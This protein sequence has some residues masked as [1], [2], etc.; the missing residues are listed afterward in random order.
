MKFKR[1]IVHFL[2]IIVISQF[3]GSLYASDLVGKTSGE[4]KVTNGTANYNIPIVVPP[5]IAEMQPKLSINYNSNSGNGILGTGFNLSGLSAISRCGQTYAQDGN[6]TGVYYT[7]KDRFMLGGSRLIAVE[8]TYGADGTIYKTENDQYSKIVSIGS[9][10]GGPISFKVWTKQG[11]I[12]EFGYSEDSKIEVAGIGANE[13]SVV[14]TWKLNKISNKFGTL[15][16]YKYFEDREYG[17]NYLIKIEY[18]NNTVE[19]V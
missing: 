5:G 2:T 9:V 7:A 16:N 17:E 11:M 15:V 13:R 1:F 12:L 6:K 8:G 14:R 4:F 3:Y 18:E 19:F 10:G